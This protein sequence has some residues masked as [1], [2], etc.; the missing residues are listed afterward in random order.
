MSL[1]TWF[2]WGTSDAS[3]EL[4]EIFPL[5]ILEKDFV[6]TDVVNIFTKI[7]TDVLE[8]TQ[9]IPED[10][11]NLLWDNCVQSESS[12]G[13]VTMLAKSISLKE[14][15]FLIYEPAI[16]LLRRAQGQEANQIRLD[17][18][19]SG[20]S[21][22]GV[23]ISFKNYSR[24]DMIRLYSCLEYCTV[25]ALSKSM[26]LSKAIQLKLSDLR[27]SVGAIDV[28]QIKAQGLLIAQGLG[29]GKDVML[30]AKD[31]IETSSPDLT[32]TKESLAFISEKRSFY[33]GMPASYM[34]G[35]TSKG[36]LSDTGEGDA[37]A[38]E[39]GLKNYFFSIIKPVV[40]TIFTVKLTFKSEDFRQINSSLE[41][42]KTFELTGDELLSQDN[43]RVIVN[44]LFGLPED[45]KGDPPAP[46][47]P[48][49]N[50]ISPQTTG[51]RAGKAGQ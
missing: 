51:G 33:L 19:N 43:K 1:T 12:D 21:S 20:E 29:A 47:E 50:N 22:L 26:N 49:N 42:L 11:Q 9:G 10:T 5:G 30:D 34:T 4:P 40:E 15:L 44:K 46:V 31:S 24:A 16:K 28:T 48:G 2:G 17:Y 7:L 35:E 45:E 18:Q 3:G 8:R 32:A 27:G 38:I 37:K 13:L 41:A 36:G 6:T 39:R 25:A 23:F 14:E